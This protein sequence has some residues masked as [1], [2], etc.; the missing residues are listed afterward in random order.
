LSRNNKLRLLILA[1]AR[2]VIGLRTWPGKTGPEMAGRVS[3]TTQVGTE[4]VLEHA[5]GW[6]GRSVG[7]DAARALAYDPGVLIPVSFTASDRLDWDAAVSTCW[8]GQAETD[9]SRV[10]DLA[11][12]K[13]HV[14]L[15]TAE[16]PQAMQHPCWQNLLLPGSWRHELRA[17]AVDGHGHCWGSITAFRNGPRPF[18]ERDAVAVGRELRHLAA[19]LSRAMIAGPTP[20]PPGNAASLWLSDNGKLLFATATGRDWLERLQTPEMPHRAQAVLAALTARVTAS[21]ARPGPADPPLPVTLRIRSHHGQWV[22][23]HGERV[24]EPTGMARGVSVVIGP[25]RPAT[26]L[27]LLAAA[28]GFTGRERE[29]ISAVLGGLSTRQISARLHITTYTV[30]DH[31][32]A[33][34]TKL[35]VTSRGELAHHL[36]SQFN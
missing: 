4:P 20:S 30:Q 29:V 23:L 28:Y 33:I 24:I 27:P 26:V 19:R 35:G 15:A 13:N 18:R 10:G 32:K 12:S 6:L 17:A 22:A 5:L 3:L 34:F 36:V 31:L 25:A 9:A 16:S 14:A 1:V 8:L 11:R 7:Y 21:A 2:N